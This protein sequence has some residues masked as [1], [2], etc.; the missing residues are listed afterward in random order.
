[1]EALKKSPGTKRH[2]H[3][4]LVTNCLIFSFWSITEKGASTSPF[5]LGVPLF[6]VSALG[7]AV[8]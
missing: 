7:T 3:K 5:V 6:A 8:A 4:E 2:I 1:M